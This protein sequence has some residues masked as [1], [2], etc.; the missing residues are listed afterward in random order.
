MKAITICPQDNEDSRKNQCGEKHVGNTHLG[1]E[2]NS[3][4][5][6]YLLFGV[7]QAGECRQ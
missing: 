6:T 3:S 2:C 7:G 1:R 4:V 5:S